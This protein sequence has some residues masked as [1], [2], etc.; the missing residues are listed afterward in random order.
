M[1]LIEVTASIALLSLILLFLAGL[2]LG[3][4]QSAKASRWHRE[5]NA[6]AL[7]FLQGLTPQNVTALCPEEGASV[8]LGRNLRAA[9]QSMPCALDEEGTPVCGEAGGGAFL[10]ELRYPPENPRLRLRRL[11]GP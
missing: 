1:T 6:L 11:V 7:N 5:A 2:Q 4:I 8:D 3:A 9:C 10:V